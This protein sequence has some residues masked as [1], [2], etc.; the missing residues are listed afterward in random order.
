MPGCE[1][2]RGSA[3]RR[4]KLKSTC[5][6]CWKFRAMKR[7]TRPPLRRSDR[8]SVRKLNALLAFLLD[9]KAERSS[10]RE[11]MKRLGEPPIRRKKKG[12]TT[13]CKRI[14]RDV[15]KPFPSL[16][17]R[18]LQRRAS[19]DTGRARRRASSGDMRIA[20]A[21]YVF[22]VCLFVCLACECVCV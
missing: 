19:M 14:P 22:F 6:R 9:V 20:M 18:G 4:R 13:S 8:V 10:G 1:G 12:N 15:S 21:V 3:S 2:A 7:W 5:A 16:R 17:L 11:R